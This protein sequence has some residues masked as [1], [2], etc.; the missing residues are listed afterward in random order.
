MSSPV[1]ELERHGIAVVPDL[2]APDVVARMR[3]AF[4]SRL[5]RMRWNDFDGYEKTEPFRHMVQDVLVLDQGFVDLAIHPVV[6]DTIG[7]YVGPTYELVEAKGWKS[8]PTTSDFHG[9]H[10]DAWYNQELVQDRI[11]R[12]VKVAMYLSDVTSG[13]F[14]YVLG[15]HRKQHPRSVQ[16]GELAGV[17]K[18]DIVEVTGRAG[19]AIF[20]DT[21]GIHRQGTP[22]LQE[23][24]AIFY[25]YHE[26]SVPL[27]KED[28][29]Y[30]RYHPLLLN[31]AFLGGLSDED[32][33]VLGFGNKT[34]YI[35]GFER[36]PGHEGFQRAMRSA[37]D[38][39]M[40][41]ERFTSR[42]QGRLRRI[43][44]GNGG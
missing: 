30:Y 35:P 42:I 10:G 27:Q 31:A 36:S 6:K 14:T 12:E 25:N 4:Q 3:V 9:W 16:D 39:K 32:R 28:L 24:L 29:D 26:P 15:S 23:R 20:F 40:K 34:N 44:G 21:S 43:L 19:T 41:A 38:A 1:E 7:S 2:L 33:R 22:I 37:F 17:P 18:Q 8:L 13:P 11:P 5:K